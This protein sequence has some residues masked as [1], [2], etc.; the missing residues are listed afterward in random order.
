MLAPLPLPLLVLALSTL[1][2]IQTHTLPTQPVE[3]LQ[4]LAPG[5]T[6][7]IEL[8]RALK[9]GHTRPGTPVDAVTTQ[10]IPLTLTTYLPRGAKVTGTVIAS[11]A[12]DKHTGSPATLTIRFDTLHYHQQVVPLVADALAIANF[13]AVGDTFA[14]TND[15]SDRGNSSPASWT[16]QQVG[17]D[18]VCRSG[19]KG[20]VFSSS[21]QPVGFADFYGVYADPPAGN[22]G[23]DAIPHAV[24]VFSTSAHGLYGFDFSDKLSSSGTEI[25]VTANRDLVLRSG[26]D[27]LLQI[28][29]AR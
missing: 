11:T 20:P 6:L 17:G 23:P 19:W 27:L 24:G 7:P 5:L 18:Q 16:T 1:A 9:A 29:P 22:I 25:T 21:M 14:S 13:T 10:R 15:G 2:A 26:D 8:T 12:A 3:T 4:P 28:L